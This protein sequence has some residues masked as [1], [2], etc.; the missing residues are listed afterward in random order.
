MLGCSSDSDKT[1]ATANPWVKIK[2]IKAQIHPPQFPDRTFNITD[3][4][5]VGDGET[6]NTEAFRKAIAAAH[7]SGGGTVLVPKGVFLTGA[8]HLKS[9]I[10]LHVSKGATIL[11][12][13]DPQDYLP[14]VFTRFEGI[15]LMNYSP[16][17]YAYKKKNIAITGQGILD[18][19]ADK[20]HWW[21]WTGSKDAGWEKGDPTDEADLKLLQK[22]N[23]KQVPPRERIF[24]RGHYLRPNFIQFYDCNTVLV[25]G[26]TIHNSPM[27]IIHPVLSENVII[28]D[29]HIDSHGPN[30]DGIDVESSKNVLI[31]N[32]YFDTGDDCI[33]IKSGKNQDG[34]RIG[35]PSE[36]IIIENSIMKD[37]HGG[38]V[39]GSET[40]GGIKNIFAQN[41]TMSSPNLDRVLRI[42]TSSKRGG[43]IQGIYMRNI[44]VGTYKE[45]AI[46]ITMF[47]T[48]PGDYMPTIRDIVVKN[49]HVKNGGK[50]GIRV[51]VYEESPVKNLKVINSTIKG[52][53]VPIKVDYVKN[54]QLDN[55]TINKKTY[56][57]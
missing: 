12:S 35:V 57:R 3:F 7:E 52:V 53:E 44:D 24:G 25:K 13:Q 41:L 19:N 9:N 39:I 49:L 51:H 11:F 38:V 45:S 21:P 26:V 47:Y 20:D 8:I 34:R 23:R 22:M 54:F 48:P 27:W 56:N 28:K 37:G 36:N 55:V 40:S 46:K 30:N 5:A 10:N 31:T 33:A 4:G 16:F 32:S 42:K 18:G 1:T 14:V 29:V 43:V 6:M 50:Y 2:K 15:E 17:I